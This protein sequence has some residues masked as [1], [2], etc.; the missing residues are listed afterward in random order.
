MSKTL[1]NAS[2]YVA[3]KQ[4]PWVEAAIAEKE[5]MQAGSDEVDSSEDE[6]D[7]LR[8]G[9]TDGKYLPAGATKGRLVLALPSCLRLVQGGMSPAHLQA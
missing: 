1:V 4:P 3:A 6:R 9:K 2:L 7:R 8:E 5:A